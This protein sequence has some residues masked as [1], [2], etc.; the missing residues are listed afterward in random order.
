M[1]LVVTEMISVSL[2]DVISEG[3][4]AADHAV[5]RRHVGAGKLAGGIGKMA[6]APM[7]EHCNSMPLTTGLTLER[8]S[9]VA[10]TSYPIKTM[11]RLTI[12]THFNG[13]HSSTLC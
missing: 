12:P 10:N 6:V 4:L 9:P 11:R 1:I 7:H 2:A 13:S 8:R 3:G 5:D